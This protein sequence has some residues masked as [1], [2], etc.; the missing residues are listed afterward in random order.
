MAKIF[1]LSLS[2]TKYSGLCKVLLA[3]LLLLSFFTLKI[4]PLP[5]YDEIDFT[6]IAHSYANNKTFVCSANDLYFPVKGKEV[7]YY[8][9]VYFVL[10]GIMLKL[11]GFGLLQARLLNFL[12]GIACVFLFI[13]LYEMLSGKKW[14][15]GYKVLFALLVF[16][17]YTYM[18]DMHSG[19]MDLLALMF[20]LA[21][22]LL[23]DISPK[24][25]WP[26]FLLSGVLIAIGLL[27]TPRVYFLVVPY[28]AYLLYMYFK[29]RRK[30]L[31]GGIACAGATACL[32][33]MGWIILKF[34]SIKAYIDYINAP[35]TV[36]D[37]AAAGFFMLNTNITAYQW[38][39]YGILFLLLVFAAWKNYRILLRPEN[40]T[41]LAT[42][43]LFLMLGGGSLIYMSLITGFIYMVVM[44]VESGRWGNRV[45]M[46]L[47]LFNFGLVSYKYF[48]VLRECDG[49]S[50]QKLGAWM[51]KSIPPGSRVVADDKYYYAVISAGSAFQYY[52]RGG[53]DM[54]RVV[55]HT[56]KWNAG[57]LLV[58]DT[59]T[60][61]FRKYRD[62]TKLELLD[63]YK[64]SGRQIL[65][66]GY[67]ASYQGFLYKFSQ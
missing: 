58:E 21:G 10:N 34:G 17:D 40:S 41:G 56:G 6:S 42:I 29:T 24:K 67:T 63:K 51:S 60:A 35:A 46:L 25:I 7:L 18:Q 30:D 43:V 59:T 37:N 66:G 8:G 49:R 4:S 47:L 65:Q 62:Y 11:F 2:V 31:L 14:S 53:S 55:Y 3:S 5:W 44:S 45:I 19:R 33:Y 12:S 16:S 20:A 52:A 23:A 9:P 57:Y 15:V 22:L 28:Y 64:P 26:H 54:D 39:T 61:L 32:V 38:V 48:V 36:F 1:F 13:N 27:T 50:P